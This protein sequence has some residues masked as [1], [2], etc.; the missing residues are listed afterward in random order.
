M[1]L[2]PAS[3]VAN[4]PMI[5]GAHTSDEVQ[6]AL[7][8]AS[9]AVESY[10]ERSFGQVLSDTVVVD[11]HYS[12][13]KAMPS[14]A[15]MSAYGS[16]PGY[17]VSFSAYGSPYIGTAMLAN[18]PVTGVSSVAAW[19][20]LATQ[21]GETGWVELV[22]YQ[23]A[24]DGLIWDTSGMPGVVMADGG[25]VPSWPRMPRSLQVTYDHG[26]TLPGT[27]DQ[28]TL[29]QGVIDAVIAAAAFYLENPTGATDIRVGDVAT[30]WE[31]SSQSVAGIL[32]STL[33]G[34]YRL[35]NL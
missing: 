1:G 22:N 2:V 18:P 27:T 11:P 12:H 8:R 7:D 4:L 21:Q 28:P 6:W 24:Q 14:I 33:L 19:M 13:V 20:P 32:D 29:P 9:A 30:K 15:P 17:G 31:P 35:V 10:C 26:Y 16:Y 23:W 5:V 34:Q 25:P 3:Q